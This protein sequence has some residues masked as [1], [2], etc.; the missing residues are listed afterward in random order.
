MPVSAKPPAKQE[1]IDLRVSRHAKTL[2][3]RAA[4]LRDKSVTQFVLDSGLAAAAETLADRREFFLDDKQWK[5][6]VTVLDAPSKP[7]PRLEKLLRTK[8][9]IE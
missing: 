1:R 7:K 5:A 2:L 8:S 3:Q 6:F 4:A 9:V